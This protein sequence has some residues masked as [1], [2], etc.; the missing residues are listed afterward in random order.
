MANNGLLFISNAAKA[1]AVCLRASKFVKR[2]LY[3][4]IKESSENTLPVLCKQIDHL[5]SKVNNFIS[6]F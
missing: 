6:C 4:K 5:Y 1:H 3:V 2:V